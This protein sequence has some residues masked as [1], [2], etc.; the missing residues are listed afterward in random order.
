MYLKDKEYF[1]NEISTLEI[2]N[3][4]LHKIF[5]IILFTIMIALLL[6]ILNL[7]VQSNFNFT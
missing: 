2:N 4:F 6:R 1:Y 7:V 3:Y 5:V